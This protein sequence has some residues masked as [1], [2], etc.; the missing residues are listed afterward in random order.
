MIYGAIDSRV[1]PGYNDRSKGYTHSLSVELTDANALLN[2]DKDETHEAIKKYNI[3]PFLDKTAENP[4]LAVDWE[5]HSESSVKISSP[6]TVFSVL[7]VAIGAVVIY[8][9]GSLFSKL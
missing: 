2:Y 3:I 7:A 6:I 9:R 4:I 1:Y 5:D 8:H